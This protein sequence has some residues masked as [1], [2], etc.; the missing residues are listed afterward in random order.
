MRKISFYL[1]FMML[2][3]SLV[4][5]VPAEKQKSKGAAKVKNIIFLIGDGMGVPALYA[6]MSVADHPL[7]IE[8]CPITGLQKTFSS[9]NYITDS[10]AAGTALACG[11]KTN[12]GTIGQDPQGNKGKS[13]LK[14]AEEKG[15]ST[16]MVV[17]TDITDATPASF[18]AHSNSRSNADAIALD[19]LKTD[20]DVFI[21]GGYN[22]FGRRADHINLIDSLKMKGYEVDTTM[23]AVGLSK[24]KKLVGLTDPLACP[25]RL[26]GRG[27]MLPQASKKAIEILSKSPK[28]FFLMIEGSH[29]D[30]GGHD[31]NQEVLVDEVLDFD[32]ALG[33]ALDFAEKD[34][35]TLVVVTADHETGGVTIVNGNM[36]SHTVKLNFSAK[37]HTAEM[38]PVFAF[39]PGAENFSGIFD[40]T[41]FLGKFLSCYKFK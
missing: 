7:N 18:V 26:K 16:G 39:G 28:G 5:W 41:A 36:K 22:H 14:I 37:G 34:G 19:F 32:E 2:C 13:I 30:H 21:G 27:N 23:I 12:N 6:G 29:I 33:V 10:A 11:I 3:L 8:R 20:I 38:V 9:D 40:N 17:V 4:S 31:N 35:N 15:L 24:A 1:Y 25:Y